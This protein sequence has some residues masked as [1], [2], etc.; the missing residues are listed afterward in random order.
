MNQ[1]VT[2]KLHWTSADL[3]VLPDNGD[4]YEIIDGDL[5]VTKAPHWN[6]QKVCGR[7][8]ALLDTWSQSTGLGQAAIAPGIIF[9]D[10]DNVIP[11]VVW[12]SHE[13]LSTLDAAGHLT[14]APEL[15]GEVLSPGSQNEY[16][17]RD[18]KLRLYSA[19]G[20]REYWLINWQT[21]QIEVYRRK[22]AVLGLVATLF[23]HDELTT[24]LLPEFSCDLTKLFS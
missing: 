4:R 2:E 23:N 11:D 24:P 22:K 1:P 3:E 20:V 6:H 21:Q 16:R 10:A 5:F 14:V 13:R 19:R 9:T 18:L 17:D 8:F 7:M 12:A 15:V